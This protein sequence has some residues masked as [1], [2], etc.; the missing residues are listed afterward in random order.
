MQTESG[1]LINK[2][3]SVFSFSIY[4]MYSIGYYLKHPD[5]F[6][7]WCMAK[8]PQIIP[9]KIYLKFQFKNCCGYR[10]N[11]KNPAT[12]NEKLQRLKLYDHN[13][14]YPKLVDKYLVKDYIAKTIWKEYIIPTLWVYDKFDD[15]DFDKLPNQFVLK[16]NHDSWSVIVCKDKK[17]FDK[18]FA[19]EKLSKALKYN[20][21]NYAKERA[22][23]N[24]TPKIIAEKYMVDES[25]TELKDY[26]I[27]CFN[28]EPKIIQ[29]D[30][31]R[32]KW[33]KRNLYDLERNLLPFEIQYPSDKNH[34]IRKPMCLDKI[35]ELAK[36]LSRWIPHVRVDFYVINEKIYFWELTFYHGAWYENFVPS[37]W[38]IKMGEWLILPNKKTK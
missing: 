38:W 5:S 21:Y 35:I 34:E 27:F 24:I 17:C 11:L 26:K 28:W 30:Y 36:K 29:V 2:D 9:A 8:A 15:I 25:W 14:K 32:F 7:F 4:I 22:Y 23:K 31:D 18:Q 13:P 33:H 1:Y 16:C 6:I 20:Y 37:A 10:P 19:K 12:F 3:S